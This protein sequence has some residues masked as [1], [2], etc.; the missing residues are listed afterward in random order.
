[1]TEE[2]MMDLSL[3]ELRVPGTSFIALLREIHNLKGQRL[4]GQKPFNLVN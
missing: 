2:L 3:R 4:W 1:M